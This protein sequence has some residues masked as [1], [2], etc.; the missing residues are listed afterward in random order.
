N[1]SNVQGATLGNAQAKGVIIDDDP[2]GVMQFSQSTY[3]VN[4]AT[5]TSVTITVNRTVDLVGTVTVNFT[6]Q[7][8]TARQGQDYG[9]TAGTLIFGPGEITKPFQVPILDDG[10]L[11]TNRSFGV[12]LSLPT[13]GATLGNPQSA[14]VVIVDNDPA[15]DI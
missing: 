3:T 5:A 6:T 7:D 11:E 15:S 13:N 14:N 4:E 2:G 1:L 10:H 8:N 12:S 9:H